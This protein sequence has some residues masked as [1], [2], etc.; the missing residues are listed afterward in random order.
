MADVGD[1]GIA[2]AVGAAIA[3]AV[4][5]AAELLRRKKRR[6]DPPPSDDSDDGVPL[7]HAVLAGRLGRAVQRIV[8]IEQTVSSLRQEITMLK[9]HFDERLAVISETLGEIRVSEAKAST[10]LAHIETTIRDLREELRSDR[11]HPSHKGGD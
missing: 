6:S 3:G 5:G 9:G 1:Q 4:A 8:A 11:R 7:S 2:A 10:S